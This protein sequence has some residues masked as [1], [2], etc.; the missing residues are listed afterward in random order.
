MTPS[1]IDH[2]GATEL[3]GG[4]DDNP[5]STKP[6][7]AF[8]SRL[9]SPRASVA[10]AP[11]H[12]PD[13]SVDAI[14]GQT[15]NAFVAGYADAVPW[16]GSLKIG[17]SSLAISGASRLP[18]TKAFPN[19]YV[20]GVTVVDSMAVRGLTGRGG[21][22]APLVFGFGGP[23]GFP[24]TTTTHAYIWLDRRAID[25]N[26]DPA[27]PHPKNVTLGWI[28]GVDKRGDMAGRATVHGEDEVFMLRRT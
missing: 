28:M 22:A 23:K 3:V 14:G 4:T 19:V 18:V 8:V 16:L 25:L 1:L 7:R 11:L 21:A 20:S 5:F 13:T 10:H 9:S 17:Q 2:V 26:T 27:L 15:D 24:G 12:I 6:P